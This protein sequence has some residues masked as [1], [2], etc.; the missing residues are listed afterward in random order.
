M[1]NLQIAST[2]NYLE[3]AY[4]EKITFEYHN[5]FFERGLVGSFSFGLKLPNSPH[6]RRELGNVGLLNRREVEPEDVPILVY[7]GGVLWTR[8][9][10]FVSGG[11][12]SEE[13]TVEINSDFQDFRNAL[14]DKKIRELL[15]DGFI[16]P[17]TPHQLAFS[18]FHYY[19]LEG[20]PASPHPF[21]MEIGYLNVLIY[22][23]YFGET[24]QF[25]FSY[26]NQDG[27]PTQDKI[28]DDIVA[29]LNGG[30]YYLHD[31][32]GT[33]VGSKLIFAQR[34]NDIGTNSLKIFRSYTLTQL[35]GDDVINETA[36]FYF[37]PILEERFEVMPER[38]GV[39][40][41]TIYN[42]DFWDKKNPA[43]F[44]YINARMPWGYLQNTYE[45]MDAY[46]YPN[47]QPR[48]MCA[49][50]KLV[51]VLDAVLAAA[52]Y[53]H[54]GIFQ[55][56]AELRKLLIYSTLEG[57]YANKMSVPD[58][59]G[60]EFIEQICELFCLVCYP[61][62]EKKNLFFDAKKS[63]LNT[64]EEVIKWDSKAYAQT[65][66]RPRRANY[67]LRYEEAEN[68]DNSFLPA[69]YEQAGIRATETIEP[70]CSTLKI[71]L[72]LRVPSSSLGLITQEAEDRRTGNSPSP[73]GIGTNNE[74]PLKLIFWR[75]VRN[76]IPIAGASGEFGNYSL[77]WAG[78][79]GLFKIWWEQYLQFLQNAHIGKFIVMLDINDLRMITRKI[80]TP[81]RYDN[82]LYLIKSLRFTISNSQ[83]PLGIPAE[84]EL[85]RI[86]A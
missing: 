43:W 78:E 75:G 23:F 48:T 21:N 74:C 7:I 63:I 20:L 83:E 32:K 17:T 42:P 71:G 39:C 69:K 27:E 8:A 62:I 16:L 37:S 19:I 52:G 41:P 38:D 82:G 85:W 61:D 84:A 49:Q 22:A 35:A 57:L 15:G 11:T 67:L 6:N 31:Y 70:K 77:E 25:S 80:Y 58:L 45:T 81:I 68:L 13:I 60:E 65:E 30:E 66:A 5:N 73:I 4:G 36:E 33:R 3:I 64:V 50:P 18:S 12:V 54:T 14:G 28:L 59:T 46:K 56:D 53:T 10:L 44:G 2:G 40:F 55:D 34:G 24:L 9:L 72:P 1:I 86:P 79:K 29:T 26:S 51:Y 76:E 47:E